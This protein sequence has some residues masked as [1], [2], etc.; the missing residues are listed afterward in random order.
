M[1]KPAMLS[2]KAYAALKAAKRSEDESLSQVI[3]RFVPPPIKTFGDLERHLDSLDGPALD[4]VDW[5]ALKRLK[6]RKAR[7][8]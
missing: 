6:R 4:G 8:H 3:L 1:G 2:E 5:A 7:A